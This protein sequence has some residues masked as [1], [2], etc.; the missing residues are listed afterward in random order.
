MSS[1]ATLRR[2]SPPGGPVGRH[3][4]ETSRSPSEYRGSPPA[5]RS[6]GPR[7]GARRGSIAGRYR[8]FG[9]PRRARGASASAG[10][11]TARRSAAPVTRLWG[12]SR[13]PRRRRDRCVI[14][15]ALT[16]TRCSHASNLSGSR[17]AR[18]C[19]HAVMN[20]SWAASRA[21]AS[22]PRIAMLSRYTPSIR[23]RTISSN[24]SRSPL[25]ARST[26]DRSVAGEIGSLLR[27]VRSSD[28]GQDVQVRSSVPSRVGYRT[29]CCIA[30]TKSAAP[31]SSSYAGR[32]DH[33]DHDAAAPDGAETRTW[34]PTRSG[35]S[36]GPD[37]SLGRV[38][39]P[40]VARAGT[41]G[42]SPDDAHGSSHTWPKRTARPRAA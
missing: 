19:R 12:I 33:R 30:A 32:I 42:S 40:R 35:S 5:Q 15:A 10:S 26:S 23:T 31:T 25:R 34:T 17:T 11:S 28:A 13:T 8:A 38:A 7:G 2:R 24:A 41:R 36:R 1:I 3:A 16:A 4:V 27:R 14:R 21:S 20:V 37:T 29:T 9:A 22:S 18:I 6:I 39:W